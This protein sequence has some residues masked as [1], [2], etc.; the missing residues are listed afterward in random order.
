MNLPSAAFN[1]KRL[2]LGK[3]SCWSGHLPFAR[4]LM[5]ALRP[6]TFVELGT[7]LGDSYFG[8]CQ[9]IAENAVDCQA[10]AVRPC[11]ETD[12]PYSCDQAAFE[13]FRHYNDTHYFAFSYLLDLPSDEAISQFEDE[14][15]GILHLNAPRTLDAATRTFNAWLP[16]VSPGGIILL[17]GIMIRNSDCGVWKFWHTLVN[18]GA[19]F[20]FRHEAGLGVF[21]KPSAHT[22]RCD[23]LNTLFSG[24]SILDAHLRRYYSLCAMELTCKHQRERGTDPQ[25][26]GKYPS[27]ND[28]NSQTD[29]DLPSV[30]PPEFASP[31]APEFAPELDSLTR[32][33]DALIEQCNTQ[34][35]RIY[36]LSDSHT[37]L[38]DTQD[39]LMR[40]EKTHDAL[41]DD[42]QNLEQAY[43]GLVNQYQGLERTFHGIIS[44][45]SWRI[46]SPLR[47]LFQMFSRS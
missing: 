39:H 45:H 24:D 7:W 14:S 11:Q 17:P 23:F 26:A 4:D 30:N 20:E 18:R 29:I 34:Q 2:N 6:S 8:F 5:A 46:T 36:L 41:K 3:N 13:S 38:K 32:E 40:L 22:A 37:V 16:K 10:Y 35:T 12:Q 28:S 25:I 42:Y 43:Q 47:S 44:S 33:R 31:A 19:T 21:E 9:A 27:Q 1:P 15:I